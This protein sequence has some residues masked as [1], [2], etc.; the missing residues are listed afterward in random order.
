MLGFFYTESLRDI[1]VI[2]KVVSV[3]I[4]WFFGFSGYW[5]LLVVWIF[6]LEYFLV[7]G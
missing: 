7:L 1:V 3:C 4:F 5:I 6:F 2:F